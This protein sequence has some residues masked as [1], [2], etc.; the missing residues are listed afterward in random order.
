MG[1]PK[2]AQAKHDRR[3]NSAKVM[4]KAGYDKANIIILNDAASIYRDA[5][6][7]KGV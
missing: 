6:G 2:A 3:V 7:L 4:K 1:V 5:G